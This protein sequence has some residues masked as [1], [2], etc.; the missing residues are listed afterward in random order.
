[1][2]PLSA[3]C[4]E[5][6]QRI[7]RLYTEAIAGRPVALLA[8]SEAPSA[9]Q[10]SGHDLPI[11]DGETLYLPRKIDDMPTAENN[12]AAY[13]VAI[14]HQLGYDA[15]GTRT[16]EW[17]QCERRVSS[18]APFLG[19]TPR[20]QPRQPLRQTAYA[21]F[22]GSFPRPGLARTLFSIL[23][24]ARVDA[25][26]LR[27]YRGIAKD[28]RNLMRHCLRNRPLLCELPIELAIVEGLIQFTLGA[29]PLAASSKAVSPETVSLEDVLPGPLRRPLRSICNAATA[30]QAPAADVYDSAA[31]TVRCY[32]VVDSLRRS[33]RFRSDRLTVE[34]EPTPSNED[35]ELPTAGTPTSVDE[36]LPVPYRGVLHP[37]LLQKRTLL[38]EL[39]AE[40]EEVRQELAIEALGATQGVP[41]DQAVE[42][43][44]VVE[45]EFSGGGQPASS[46][47]LDASEGKKQRDL[48]GLEETV[49]SLEQELQHAG[50][51]R[52]KI[53]G[54]GVLY[55]EWDYGLGA[56]RPKWCRLIE[57]PLAEASTD[58]L[59]KALGESSGLLREV[60][61]QFE[62]LKPELLRRIKRL[63]DGEEI[64]LDS[65][66][67]AYVDRRS[68]QAILDKVYT[69]RQRAERDV[70]TAFL[71]DMSAS[72]DSEVP[73]TARA[74]AGTEPS[75]SESDRAADKPDGEPEGAPKVDFTG[76]LGDDDDWAYFG[77][78]RPP[79]ERRRVIDVEKEAVVL[80]A[81]ALDTLGD[82][83]AIYGFS[84]FGREQVDFFIAKDFDQTYDEAAQARIAAMKPQRSTRMGP[85]IR[86][87][88]RKLERTEARIKALLILSDGYPQDFDYGDDRASRDY[89]IQDTMMAL[90][91]ARIRGIQT[92][93][94]TV[95][96]A[97]HDYLREMCPDRQYLVID[98][99]ASLPS[100]LPKVYQGLTT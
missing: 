53:E 85:A 99:V 73:L 48:H 66:I 67:E 6:H 72:T 11:W 20:R 87:A 47:D 34:T 60:R 51:S 81:E 5:D 21:R 16:L 88:T 77:T 23:E 13:K 95:D 76:I 10:L 25:F 26:L 22:F 83:Y 57:Q 97:G 14:L 86:H 32:L 1:M 58:A 31:A 24:D 98:D 41:E 61:R 19:E 9:L 36:P 64:D 100:E 4:F 50:G 29:E 8:S 63:T 82:Q 40:I 38:E 45:G 80:M 7:L 70:A 79:I 90:R 46:L 17:R 27:T 28:L 91:E 43:T 3:I 92:F 69:R 37:E 93:C 62:Q 54:Q 65:A 96:P 75:S 12:F 68:G 18:L 2:S 44:G 84:G 15:I 35:A 30:I 89:G 74:T 71:L 78:P 94:I 59:K 33:H 42:I 49:K 52:G 56:Y 39:S 55:D